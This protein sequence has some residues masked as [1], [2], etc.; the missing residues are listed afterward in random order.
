MCSTFSLYSLTVRGAR[1]K[2]LGCR[3]SPSAP[4]RSLAALIEKRR[5]PATEIGGPRYLLPRAWRQGISILAG[6]AI[7]L[8]GVLRLG[9]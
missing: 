9:A 6:S 5:G 8:A 2:N 1:S 3:N 7:C 4:Q